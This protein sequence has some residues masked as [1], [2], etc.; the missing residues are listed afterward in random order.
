MQKNFGILAVATLALLLLVAG[1]APA[2]DIVDKAKD[3]V[4]DVKDKVKDTTEDVKGKVE[5]E[6][7][8]LSDIP[9]MPHAWTIPVILVLGIAIG[10]LM[11]R[12]SSGKKKE[13]KKK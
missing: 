8:K 2:S 12:R 5:D 13:K 10:F 4:S 3:T 6:K 11:G 1:P 9:S 7:N